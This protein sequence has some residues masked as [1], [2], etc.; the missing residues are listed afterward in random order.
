MIC[1]RRFNHFFLPCVLL[2]CPL[3]YAVAIAGSL[4]SLAISLLLDLHVDICLNLHPH[5][6]IDFARSHMNPGSTTHDPSLRPYFTLGLN[7]A[8]SSSWLAASCLHRTKN[9]HLPYYTITYPRARRLD[10]SSPLFHSLI[11][12]SSSS[13]SASFNCSR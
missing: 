2:L 1:C 9:H 3:L 10:G 4:G 13:S 8:S 11:L 5:P 12:P 7:R 6:P